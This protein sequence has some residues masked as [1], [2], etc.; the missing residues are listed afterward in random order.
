MNDVKILKLESTEDIVCFYEELD[1]KA[2]ISNPLNVY[3]EYNVKQ[4][5]QNLVMNYWLPVNLVDN[6]EVIID[7]SRI[8]AVMDPKPEFKEF[9]LNFISA[10]Q[11]SLFDEPENEELKL[12][13]ESIDAKNLNKIH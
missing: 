1:N 5:S 8:L 11:N 12:L 3:I 13:L 10:K 7:Q 4:K 6:Q 2:K 9:Y